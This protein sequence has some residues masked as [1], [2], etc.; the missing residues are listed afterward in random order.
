MYEYQGEKGNG[1]Q[2]P[3]GWPAR[4]EFSSSTAS[5]TRT[6]RRRASTHWGTCQ[7]EAG[8]P[9]SAL[10]T[11]AAAVAARGTQSPENG[12]GE[13]H[14][15]SSQLR[16]D[17]AAAGPALTVITPDNENDNGE[18]VEQEHTYHVTPE[19][20]ADVDRLAHM[21][22][23]A[24]SRPAATSANGMTRPTARFWSK[25][26]D[27]VEALL[28]RVISSPLVRSLSLFLPFAFSHAL[29]HPTARVKR[30][31][32]KKVSIKSQQRSKHIHLISCSPRRL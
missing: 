8:L 12:S 32:A 2:P 30:P 19:A 27:K 18:E 14:E 25:L 6:S 3:T 24:M 28:A 20:M 31:K 21:L 15:A 22:A 26:Q 5:I 13:G 11:R 17:P 9:L 29:F 7:A 10:A 23:L 4:V 16:T 1:C